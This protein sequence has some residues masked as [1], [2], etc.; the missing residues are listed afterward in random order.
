MSRKYAI[1]TTDHLQKIYIHIFA[2]IEEVITSLVFW[3]QRFCSEEGSAET[4]IGTP[5]EQ[6]CIADGALRL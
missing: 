4:L 6:Q 2:R 1:K 3:E 5:K